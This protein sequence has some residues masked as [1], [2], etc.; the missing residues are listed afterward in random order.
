LTGNDPEDPLSSSPENAPTSGTKTKVVRHSRIEEI[1]LGPG[2]EK[3]IKVWYNPEPEEVREALP[4]SAEIFAEACFT[5]SI[6]LFN[7]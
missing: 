3:T 5:D 4:L 2:A 7:Q 6:T 1:S